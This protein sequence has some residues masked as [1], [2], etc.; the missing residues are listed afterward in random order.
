MYTYCSNMIC[1][2]DYI[3][4]DPQ[5]NDFV[6]MFKHEI[7]SNLDL[8]KPLEEFPNY[9]HL[10]GVGESSSTQ[11]SRSRTPMPS[12]PPILGEHRPDEDAIFAIV[13]SKNLEFS[14]LALFLLSIKDVGFMGD[15]VLHIPLIV[16]KEVSEF[17]TE[18]S[19]SFQNLIVY[20]GVIVPVKGGENWTISSFIDTQGLLTAEDPRPPRTFT[21]VGF[22]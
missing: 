3:H 19:K 12:Q 18:Y 1:T 9:G 11:R 10:G 5:L 4:S 22:E 7:A 2:R 21:I 17:L 8:T 16:P 20:E 6:N 13:G 14:N 15:I